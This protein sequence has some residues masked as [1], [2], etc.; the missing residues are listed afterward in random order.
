MP[1][2][3]VTRRRYALLVDIT[4]AAA[5]VS[6]L[7]HEARAVNLPIEPGVRK[8]AMLSSAGRSLSRRSCPSLGSRLA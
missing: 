5:N 1:A 6:E 8:A 3:D 2:D 4:Q 7:I